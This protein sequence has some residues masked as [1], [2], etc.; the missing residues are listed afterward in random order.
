MRVKVIQEFRRGGELQTI[1]SMI[2]IP[3]PLLPSLSNYVAL[4]DDYDAKKLPTYCAA[5]D[6]WCS[7]K[8]GLTE[9]MKCKK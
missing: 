8:I 1:N 2:D 9:C 5:G 3:A 4:P 7:S 6:A